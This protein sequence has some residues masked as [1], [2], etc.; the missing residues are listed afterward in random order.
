MYYLCIVFGPKREQI[1]LSALTA[2][3]PETYIKNE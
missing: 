3:T 2:V 1:G